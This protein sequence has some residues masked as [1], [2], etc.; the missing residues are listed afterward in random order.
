MAASEAG[1]GVSARLALGG[2]DWHVF[3]DPSAALRA[4]DESIGAS[5]VVDVEAGISD[6]LADLDGLAQIV[7]NLLDNAARHAEGAADRSIRVRLAPHAVPGGGARFV[8]TLRVAGRRDLAEPV[9]HDVRR[10][11]S[12]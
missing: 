1:D 3:I 8:L 9:V 2:A 7:Q 10:R 12:E 11:A 4:A 5:V 6:V